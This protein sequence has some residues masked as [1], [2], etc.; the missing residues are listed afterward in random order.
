MATAESGR[1]DQDRADAPDPDRGGVPT[2]SQD[3]DT[4]AV[5]RKMRAE[6]DLFQQQ[7][8]RHSVRRSLGLR[9]VRR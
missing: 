2:T 4:A 3:K 6:L 8:R 1:D 7:A 9:G 5:Q